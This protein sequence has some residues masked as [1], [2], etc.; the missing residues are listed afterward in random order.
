M[1]VCVCVC[2][3]EARYLVFGGTLFLIWDSKVLC[4]F[5]CVCLCVAIL[6]QAI[7]DQAAAAGRDDGVRMLNA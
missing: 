6:A 3:C 5:V 4:V 7:L 1:C 2:V